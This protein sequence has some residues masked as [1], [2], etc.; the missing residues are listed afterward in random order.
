M[1]SYKPLLDRSSAA[2]VIATLLLLVALAWLALWPTR[3]FA[4]AR[5][6]PALACLAS[7][8][9]VQFE[10]PL[11]GQVHYSGD[12]AW[13]LTR[14]V[15][16]MFFLACCLAFKHLDLALRTLAASA[17]C[18][19]LLALTLA[20]AAIGLWQA[21]PGLQAGG[22][23]L[24]HVT[25]GSALFIELQRLL[26]KT[27]GSVATTLG[28]LL[29]LVLALVAL[30]W[31]M[32]GAS[33]LL[34]WPLTTTLLVYAL[35]QHPRAAAWPQAARMAALAAGMAPA[36]VLFAPLLRHAS[37][38]LTAEGSALLMLLMA[39]M[40]GT[41]TTLLAALRRRFV[42]ALLML[43]CAGA[44]MAHTAVKN[45][46]V[47]AAAGVALNGREHGTFSDCPMKKAYRHVVSLP[48][49][50]RQGPDRG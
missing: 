14:V 5:A 19:V 38:L 45:D 29:V 47:V 50:C 1:F 28:T 20:V 32:P 27:L 12:Q 48:E 2:V 36:I 22:Y 6:L 31:R 30:S 11:V 37:T 16:L 24:A 42:A 49:R 9:S 41:G 10:L 13:A 44:L 8:G 39:A 23:L 7:A 25:L 46:D 40:L 33:Y 21:F 17:M 15:C 26:H 4:A 35:L 3:E 18:F 43:A 34:A